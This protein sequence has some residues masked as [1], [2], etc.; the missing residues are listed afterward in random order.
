MRSPRGVAAALA[1]LSALPIAALYQ[2]IVGAGA[3]AVVHV[4]L[5]LGAALLAFAVFDFRTA[6]W[7]A[8]T[9]CA[10]ASV[11]AV[12]FLLQAVSEVTR[13]QALTHF[14]YRVLGQRLEGWLANLVLLWCL[15]VVLVDSR[16]KTRIVGLVALAIVACVEIYAWRLAV[17]GGSLNAAA[18]G[19]KA[20]Y[21]LPFVWLLLEA[22]KPAPAP[23]R[24]IAP[25]DLLSS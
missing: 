2:T 13:S 6:R 17:L 21:L 14:V 19:L 16:G 18:P 10:A 12:I 25:P 11:M 9:G 24:A 5:A 3:E 8:W 20:L 15:A 23:V 7:I 22:R 4:V 1:F